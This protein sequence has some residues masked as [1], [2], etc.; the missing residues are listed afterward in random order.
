MPVPLAA[1]ASNYRLRATARSQQLPNEAQRIFTAKVAKI[2]NVAKGAKKRKEKKRKD[3]KEA[4]KTPRTNPILPVFS[5]L[6]PSFAFL[7]L[8]SHP[9]LPSL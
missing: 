1:A 3:R 5:R 9:S 6:L 4:E 8:P 7:R 2:A